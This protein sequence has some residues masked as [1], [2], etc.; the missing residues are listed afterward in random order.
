MLSLSTASRVD[1]RKGVHGRWTF[2]KTPSLQ[3]L[4][5]ARKVNQEDMDQDVTS[6]PGAAAPGN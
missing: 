3:V 4:S 6:M 5:A 1:W 2:L